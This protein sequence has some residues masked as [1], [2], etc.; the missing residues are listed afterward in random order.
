[1][2]YVGLCA[3]H[4]QRRRKKI[5]IGWILWPEDFFRARR[6]CNNYPLM[7]VLGLR[8]FCRPDLV[9]HGFRV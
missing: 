4:F 5:A 9:D 3:E 1:M 7:G 6:F 8:F 2:I